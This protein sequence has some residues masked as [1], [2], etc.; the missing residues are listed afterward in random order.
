MGQVLSEILPKFFGYKRIITVTIFGKFIKNSKSY[1]AYSNYY[2]YAET[3]IT[4]LFRFFIVLNTKKKV[5]IHQPLYNLFPKMNFSINFS[6]AD[7]LTTLKKGCNM[8]TDEQRPSL[9][10]R[11]H[12]V[13]KSERRWIL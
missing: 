13:F 10:V 8:G 6:I 9:K 11:V 12:A 2:Y 3:R 7:E 1:S 5:I 4:T